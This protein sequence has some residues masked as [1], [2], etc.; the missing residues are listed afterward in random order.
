MDKQIFLLI[1][2]FLGQYYLVSI[3]AA[4]SNETDQDALL[5]FQNLVT[6][7]SHS[8][9]KNWTKNT[10]FCSWFGV[11]CNTKR[12][13]VVSLALP[14][15]QLQGTISP[16]LA[17]LSSLRELNLVN[18]NIQGNI[19]TSLFQ[20]QRIQNISLAFN[21]L[22]GEIFQGPWYLP[23]LRVLDLT[24]NNLT[25]IIPLSIGNA[26]KL[27]YLSLSRN[28]INSNIPNEI[29]NLSRLAMLSLSHNQLTGPIP[30]I[31][32]NISSLISIHL[33]ANRL[34]GPLLLNVGNLKSNLKILGIPYNQISG[35]FPSNICQFTELTVFSIAFNNITGEIPRNIGCL[36]KLK[37]FFV[38]NNAINGT[39][40]TSLGNI[41][42]LQSLHCPNNHVEGPIPLELGKLSNLRMLDFAENYNLIGEIPKSIFNISS[43]EFISLSLNNFSGRIPSTTGLHLPNL[44]GLYLADNQIEGEIPPFITNSTKLTELVLAENFFTGKIPANLGN[45]RELQG[46]FLVKNQLT[47]EPSEHEL[48]FLNSLVDCRMLQ[49]LS[50]GYNPLNGILPNS[51]GNLS[52]AIEYFEIAN[53]R[54]NGH[55]PKSI[56][57]MTGLTMLDFQKNNLKGSIPSEVSKLKQLQGLYLHYNKLQGHIPKVV[58]QLSSLVQLILHRNELSGVIPECIGNLSMLQELWLGSN[59]FASK[60]PLSLWQLT[61]LLHLNISKNSLQGEVP[62]N[63]GELKAIIGLDFSSNHFSGM[64]P[65]RIG[66]LENMQYLSLSNNS[67]L[68]SIPSS[69]SNLISMEF[70]DLSLNAISGTIPVSL[71]KLSRLRSINVSFN[72]LEGEIPNGGVFANSTPQSFVGNKGLCGMHMLEVPACAI[73]NPRRHS[74]SKK[75]VLKIVTPVVTSSFLIFFLVSIWIMIQQRKG[76]SKDA[77]KLPELR[78]YQLISYHEIRRATN[79]FDVSNLIGVGG[80]GSVYRGTLSSGTVVAIKVL[81][82]Q[83][84][85]TCKRFDTESEVIRNVRHRNLVP[86]I[87]TCSSEHIRAFVLQYMPNGSLE[88]WLYKEESHLNLLQRVTIMLDVAVAIE[89]LHHGYGTPIIHCDLKPANVL[90]DKDMVAHVGDFGISKILAGNKS[91]AHTATLGT[92]GYIAPEYGSEGIVST[93]G[94]VYSY[95]IM[96]MEVLAKRRPTDEEIFSESLGIRE[97]MRRAFSG[98]MM[99]IVDANLFFEEDKITSKS[100]NCIASMIEL[101]LDCTNEKPESRIT[102]KDVVKRLNK[103][104]NTFLESRS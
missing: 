33:R 32:F 36:A 90:L 102:V 43:L 57:N 19:P 15:L 52:S 78:T 87:T 65:S 82:L 95:G 14:N 58:C 12:Q 94:D 84:E 45:L 7:P 38:G 48:L 60:L 91:T 80:S 81:D 93:S 76:K 50:F 67:F 22:S 104:K 26:T 77:E 51:I 99:E 69:F 1:L 3:S 35:D 100:E 64:I 96:F 70:L 8:L 13:R 85:E 92:L 16:S 2:L 68:G 21:K 25:G 55:I 39:I 41:S 37:K 30:A 10:S 46:L 88:N 59:N 53:A 17:N 4:S 29:G 61:G 62:L 73:S 11:T 24:N 31:L 6:S 98:T 44:N 89:Y 49:Y 66:E 103:I 40:P 86:V 23:E 97:W 20:H 27:L 63:I 56:G 83:N 79:N 9:A 28:R 34:S 74:K 18:N 54:I 42:T 101:A 5:T 47:N 75:L 72:D 71:E